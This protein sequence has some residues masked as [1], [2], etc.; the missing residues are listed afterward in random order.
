MG[1]PWDPG[2]GE[3][4][5]ELTPS[6]LQG[7]HRA[8]HPRT[9]AR[10]PTRPSVPK[11]EPGHV[12]RHADFLPHNCFPSP[13]LPPTA[14]PVPINAS[15]PK[16]TGIG[17]HCL[18]LGTVIPSHHRFIFALQAEPEESQPHL[19]PSPR[20]GQ[21]GSPVTPCPQARTASLGQL[22]PRLPESTALGLLGGPL[23]VGVPHSLQ[24]PFKERESTS[25]F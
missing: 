20:H 9:V 21:K 2:E 13:A 25:I 5:R 12:L 16:A 24:N 6:R 18:Q 3:G 15:S 19:P 1:A 7:D 10:A 8:E 17:F 11:R 22:A 14:R 4:C 23:P